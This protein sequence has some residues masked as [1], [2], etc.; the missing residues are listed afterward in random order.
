MGHETRGKGGFTSSPPALQIAQ[1]KNLVDHK[2]V[3]HILIVCH[4][5]TSRS[6]MAHALLGKMLAERKVEHI[7]IR[8]GGIALY[9]RDGMLPSLDARLVLRD[10][11]IEL[12]ENDIVSTDLKRHGHLI[13]QADLILTMTHEQKQMLAA[14]PE[15]AGKRVFT[16][17]EFAGEDGDIDDPAMQGEEAFRARLDE[18]KRC[19]EKSFEDLLE[20]SHERL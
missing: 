11:D 17:K 5:N 7:E 4:A 1:Q 9:A 13:A 14:H 19:L 12:R 10:I 8:S 6:I 16:L 2:P 15:T 20:L 18:I 3:W